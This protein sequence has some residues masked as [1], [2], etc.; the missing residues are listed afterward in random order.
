MPDY[1]EHYQTRGGN[2]QLRFERRFGHSVVTVWRA[3]T[4]PEHLDAWFPT[5]I[6]GLRSTGARL[7]LT[8]RRLA[9]QR[10]RVALLSPAPDNAQGHPSRYR[11]DR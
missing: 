3:V 10:F 5:T 4:E 7:R 1:G 8:F 9:T 2:W 6:D 11:R